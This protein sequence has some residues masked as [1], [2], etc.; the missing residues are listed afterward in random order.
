MPSET[1]RICIRCCDCLDGLKS[2]ESDS[3]SCVVTSPPYNKGTQ[4]Q[5]TGN[6]IWKGFKI[7]YDEYK[8]NMSDEDYASWMIEVL[9]ELHRV[10]KPDGS[11]FFNHKVI[12]RDC[13]GHFPK[14]VLESRLDLYQMVVWDRQ[15]SSNMRSETLYPT[16]E[17][18]FWLTK[19]KPSVYKS[20]ARFKNDIWPI[21]PDRNNK[22]PAPFPYAL[23]EN[24]VN[25]ACKKGSDALVLDP[26]TGSGTVAVA[27]KANGLR[28]LGFELSQGYVDMANARLSRIERKGDCTQGTLL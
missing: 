5:K 7:D 10:I 23:A 21:L 13:K 28:F 27:A 1:D 26:F 8:D 6:Q 11:V 16:H 9:N 12:L 15:C 18:I 2:V 25:L 14:W 4:N 22:H 17:L 3:V 24:C 20:Q 19:G